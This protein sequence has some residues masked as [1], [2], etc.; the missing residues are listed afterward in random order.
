MSGVFAGFGRFSVRF[1]WLVVVVWVV[2]TIVSVRALPTLAS[3]VNNNNGAFLP[4]TAPSNQA[5]VLAQPLIGPVTHS[6]IPVVA[7]T[8]GVALSPADRA[9]VEDVAARLGRVPSVPAQGVRFTGVSPNGRAVQLLVTSTTS[10]FDVGPDKMVINDLN[11]ALRS[12]HLPH[13]LHVYLAGEVATNVANQEQSN[14]QGNEVQLASVLFIIVLLLLIFR[15]VLAPLVT[16]LPAVLVL[17]LSSSLIGG[18]GSAGFLQVSFFTQILLIVLLLGPGTDYGLFLVFRVREELHAGSDPREAVVKAV[19]RVGESITASAGTVIV[20]LLTLLLADFGLYHD[21]AVPL[22]IGIAV[23]LLSGLTLLPALLAIL[24]RAVFWP[25]ST[26]QR[27]AT[28]GVWGRVA[29]RLVQRPAL[30]VV[31]GVLILGAFALLALG[32]KPGGFGGDLSA[33]AGSMVARGNAAL[34]RNFPQSTQNPTNVVM[35]FPRSVWQDPAPLQ[36]ADQGLA[37]TGSFSR[38]SGP[39]S[40]NGQHLSPGQLVALH[41]ELSR[42]GSAQELVTRPPVPPPGSGVSR[43]EYVTYLSTALYVSA[44]GHTVQ[45]E[46]GLRAGNAGTT[47]ALDAVPGL[48]KAVDAVARQAGATHS[49][50]AGEA[51]PSTTSAIF[52]ART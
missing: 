39:L 20:A 46:T 28:L 49:G 12:A 8:S 24:G 36:V 38:I 1:R 42:Y 5:A 34:A 41:D 31:I 52:Q 47:A 3:Q 30:T 7:V 45:W 19:R 6:Q 4:P 21:L 9:A 37:A 35:R 10:P 23:M 51:P 2:G 32:F 27:P 29:S 11:E 22:A 40:P 17:V 25:T 44:D 15:A 14:R 50:V 16:L 33:P 13:D 26:R 48:R 43:A 18:L